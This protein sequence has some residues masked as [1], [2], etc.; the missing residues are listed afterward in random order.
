MLQS[1][2]NNGVGKHWKGDEKKMNIITSRI[3]SICLGLRKSKLHNAEASVF[4][5]SSA[6]VVARG[7]R[8]DVI[9]ICA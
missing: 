9:G 2:V 7:G 6:L 5:F 3:F 1:L 8:G 4:I